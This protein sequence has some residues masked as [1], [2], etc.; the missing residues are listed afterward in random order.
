MR[1]SQPEGGRPIFGSPVGPG[2]RAA[3]VKVQL[4]ARRK[5]GFSWEDTLD[6]RPC[7]RGKK[8]K[9]MEKG[10]LCLWMCLWY[11]QFGRK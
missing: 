9:N 5:G 10:M 3:G 1:V 11:C 2:G 7:Q 4:G 8:G 6:K